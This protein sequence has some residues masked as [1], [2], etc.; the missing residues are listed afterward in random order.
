MC[1]VRSLSP[2]FSCSLRLS[3]FHSIRF[4]QNESLAAASY[5]L[6]RIRANVNSICALIPMHIIHIV[7]QVFFSFFAPRSTCTLRLFFLVGSFGPAFI[8]FNFVVM[9]AACVW[10]SIKVHTRCRLS[11]RYQYGDSAKERC[12]LCVKNAPTTNQ[13][14]TEGATKKDRSYTFKF[15][16]N[17]IANTTTRLPFVEFSAGGGKKKHREFIK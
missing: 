12:I 11:V 9:F 16:G 2:S 10:K 17:A 15:L 1:F 14:E 8:L 4:I 13:I 5:K 3:F 6:V 7:F